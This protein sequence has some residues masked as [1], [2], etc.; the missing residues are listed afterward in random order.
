MSIFLL[1]LGQNQLTEAQ[2]GAIKERLPDHLQLVHTNDRET[3]E[4][5]APHVEAI[6]GW[7]KPSSLLNMPNLKW[8]HFWGVGTDWLQKHPEMVDMPFVLTN[9]AGH[10]RTQITEHIF[11]MLLTLARHLDNAVLAQHA[12]VWA[13]TY[14]PPEAEKFKDT[15]FAHSSGDMFELSDKTMLILGLGGIGSRTAKLAKAFDMHTIG[16]RRTVS[17]P[18]KFV[19][20]LVGID[21]L[22]AVLP[23]ADVV[24]VTLPYTQET[25]HLLNAKTLALMKPSSILINIGRGEI[26]D[27]PALIVALR[28]KTIRA[29]ALDVFEQEPLPADSPLW[30]MKNVLITSHYAGSSPRYHER[31]GQIFIDNLERWRDGRPLNNLV[32]K[33]AGY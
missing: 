5:V 9:V 8:A 19:D 2:M 13:R 18:A 21:Q 15:P 29:A 4:Q 6:A 3:I 11:G 25:H 24:V 27:E 10:S 12:A 1:K 32:D 28:N 30:Q 23:K 20:R 31:A 22:D 26:I 16:V 33:K 17:K 7:F 14:S